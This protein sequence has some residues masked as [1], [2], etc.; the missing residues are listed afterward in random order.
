MA[1]K[2]ETQGE[3][4][5]KYVYFKNNQRKN[6]GWDTKRIYLGPKDVALEILGELQTEPLIDEKLKTYSGEVI[7]GKIADS[8]KLNDVLLSCTGN[9]KESCIMRKIIILRTLFNKSKLTPRFARGTLL[10]PHF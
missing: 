7:L 2:I 5:A 3:Y 9:E 10:T 4:K 6:G 1:W 8:I